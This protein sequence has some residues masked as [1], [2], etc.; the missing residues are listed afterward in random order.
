M[1]TSAVC[2]TGLSTVNFSAEMG[3]VSQ[4]IMLCLIQIGGLGFMTAMMFLSLS[5]GR[6]IGLKSRVFFLGGLGIDGFEGAIRLLKVVLRFTFMFESVGALCLFVGFINKGI[7]PLTSVYYAIFHSISAFCNAGFS[8]IPNGLRPFATDIIVPST[9]M[10]LIVLGGIGF[11]VFAEIYL[12]FRDKRKLSHYAKLVTI[13]TVS[14]IALG[15]GVFFITEWNNAFSDLS[16]MYKVWNSL[17]ASITARTAG[18]DTI[19][20]GAF[21]TLGQVTMIILMV[22]GASPSSTGGG[23]KTTTIAVLAISVWNEINGRKESIFMHRRIPY[24]S[25]RRALAL[26]VVYVL[27]FLF[28]A[29]VLS[30]LEH[31]PFGAVIYETASA[32]GTVGLTVGITQNFSPLGRIILVFLMFWGRVGILSF[33]TSLI[34]GEKASEIHYP[35]VN[36]PV[37]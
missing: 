2:V 19:N 9:I 31:M 24:A 21:S 25:E 10:S 36:I 8:P 14:L 13:I 22:I 34:S 15:T 6:R 32:M 4:L 26:L 16:L 18:F 3:F 7:P 27:T 33:F 12:F 29:I 20:P 35:D 17:F 30:G 11:P 28:A 23:L 37:G 1:S 5:V